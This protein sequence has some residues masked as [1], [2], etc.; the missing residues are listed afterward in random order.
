M[1]DEKMAS[2]DERFEMVQAR[3]AAVEKERDLAIAHDRQPYPTADAYDAA[4]AALEKHRKRADALAAA[5]HRMAM[6]AYN[7]GH[8]A[9]D[10]GAT[11]D[12]LGKI[13]NIGLNAYAADREAREARPER[14]QA[15]AEVTQ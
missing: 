12:L 9:G 7:S 10:R 13:V 3:I 15:N 2:I 8:V 11:F 14:M 6:T 1:S 4:C 5:V